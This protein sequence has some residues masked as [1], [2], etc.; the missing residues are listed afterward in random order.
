[1]QTY[2]EFQS[3]YYGLEDGMFAGHGFASRIA[4]YREPGHSGYLIDDETNLAVD[5]EMQKHY[6]GC[7][8]GTSG[9]ILPCEMSVGGKYTECIND[10]ELVKC[11]D[12]LSQ[13]DCSILT[14]V[15]E[16]IA[17][18]ANIKWCT[19]YEIKEST[20]ETRRGYVSR[21][22]HCIN[23]QGIPSET[24]GEI[25]KQGTEEKGGCFFGDGVTPV[26]RG[27]ITGDFGYCGDDGEVC[28]GTHVGSY[29]SRDY[30]PRV[31]FS[32]I[33][34]LVLLIPLLNLLSCT[35]PSSLDSKYLSLVE[36]LVHRNERTTSAQL[37]SSISIFHG[38]PDRH[39]ILLAHLQ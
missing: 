38:W 13:K 35:Y 18:E 32:L 10:C 19:N 29:I 14:D 39:H 17:C 11:A 8:N 16:T 20:N 22:T 28:N 3:I 27:N 25:V 7:M 12:E 36:R 31:S 30:D 37:E 26:E 23:D 6:D 2:P 24:P 5:G 1:M 15:N 33:L 4:N 34:V 21:G 9:E